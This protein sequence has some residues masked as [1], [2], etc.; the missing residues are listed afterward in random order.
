MRTTHGCRLRAGL[1]GGAILRR[2]RKRRT[3]MPVS[4]GEIERAADLLAA[5]SGYASGRGGARDLR[6]RF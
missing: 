2:I 1:R 6:S 5:G 4:V 3:K